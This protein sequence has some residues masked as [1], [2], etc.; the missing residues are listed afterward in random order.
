MGLIGIG[1]ELLPEFKAQWRKGTTAQ[2]RK[3]PKRTSQYS[4]GYFN[5]LSRMAL[6]FSADGL[7]A[8]ILPSLSTRNVPPA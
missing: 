6:T 8:R 3:G 7:I 5:F 4:F 1:G 2:R